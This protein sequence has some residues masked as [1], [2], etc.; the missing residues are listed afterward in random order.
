MPT[1]L[2]IW[3]WKITL[4]HSIL[5]ENIKMGSLR[6]LTNFYSIIAGILDRGVI[7]VTSTANVFPFG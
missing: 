6:R 3:I 5:R 1:V 2:N 4:E 7:Q